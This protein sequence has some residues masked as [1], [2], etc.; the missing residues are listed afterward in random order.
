MKLLNRN[1]EFAHVR[2]GN[3][4]ED[5]VALPHLAP[6]GKDIDQVENS[7]P[8]GDAIPE[9]QVN[10]DATADPNILREENTTE[11]NNGCILFEKQQ[12]VR[13]YNLRTREA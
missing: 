5:T 7:I 6:K 9:Q 10:G 11:T 4:R 12:R 8:E 2:F 13:P 3:G 1:P